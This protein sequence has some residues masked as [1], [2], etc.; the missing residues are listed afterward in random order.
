MITK[1]DIRKLQF[2]QNSI[3]K[4]DFIKAFLLFSAKKKSEEDA[5]YLANKIWSLY[6]ENHRNL[7]EVI[8][9]LDE[10]VIDILIDIINRLQKFR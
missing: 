5:R 10:D 6:V 8:N 2:F 9:Y 7:I 4:D 3:N 1:D